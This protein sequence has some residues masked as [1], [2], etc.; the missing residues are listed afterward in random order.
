MFPDRSRPIILSHLECQGTPGCRCHCPAGHFWQLG[1]P[2]SGAKRPGGQTSQTSK[3]LKALVP[4]C[5]LHVSVACLPE[6]WSFRDMQWLNLSSRRP[7]HAYPHRLWH[8][9]W[10]LVFCS[11]STRS[12]QPQDSDPINASLHQFPRQKDLSG[13][14]SDWTHKPG[15][16]VKIHDLR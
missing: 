2:T 3:S 12:F 4:T 11:G 14:G 1:A 9:P 16:Q 8:K 15:V 6:A 7:P 13:A 10:V 5:V